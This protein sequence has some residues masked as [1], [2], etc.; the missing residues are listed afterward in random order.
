MSRNNYIPVLI[1]IVLIIFVV[2]Q[3]QNA[4]NYVPPVNY[5]GVKIAN[6]NLQIFGETKANNPELMNSYVEKIK[7]YD[8][9]FAQEIRD[10]SGVAYSSLCNMLANYNCQISSRA[11]TTSSKEQY[12][13]I[14]KKDIQLV[15]F[16]DFNLLNYSDKFERPP[17]RAVFQINYT[18]YTNLTNYTMNYFNI[19]AWNI[20]I[21]PDNVINEASELESLIPYKP[22]TIILGDLNFDCTYFDPENSSLFRGWNWVIKNE[23]D[24]TVS[25]TNCAY[26][27]IFTDNEMFIRIQNSGIDKD[28]TG[29]QSDHYLVWIQIARDNSIVSPNS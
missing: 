15:E 20:H 1:F 6:W 24:T 12:L 27:R 17:I 16:E 3:S 5:E 11:G 13:I 19:T 10:N 18:Q 22:Q 29:E 14:Y 8:I 25:S 26:D 7:K 2:Y 28:V 9:V 4:D 23:D 21:K